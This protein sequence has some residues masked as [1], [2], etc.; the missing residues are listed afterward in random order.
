MVP[1]GCGRLSADGHGRPDAIQPPLHRVEHMVMRPS[2]DL[3]KALRGALRFEGAVAADVE[4]WWMLAREWMAAKGNSLSSS[5]TA[6]P[7]VT[8]QPAVTRNS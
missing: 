6:D 2:Q 8:T 5:K 1:N 3:L 4:K 7:S